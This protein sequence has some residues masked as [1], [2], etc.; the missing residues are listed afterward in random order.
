MRVVPGA[1]VLK[2]GMVSFVWFKEL[3]KKRLKPNS[4]LRARILEEAASS[5][6]SK[7]SPDPMFTCGLCSVKSIDNEIGGGD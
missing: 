4:T 5:L 7:Q 1:E 3:V 6:S 2:P